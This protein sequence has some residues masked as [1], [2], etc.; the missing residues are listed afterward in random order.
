MLSA[1]RRRT[2]NFFY[3]ANK[4][5]EKA[6]SMTRKKFIDLSRSCILMSAID[7]C[8]SLEMGG[9]KRYGS[10]IWNGNKFAIISR[11]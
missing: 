8:E 7:N 2:E 11:R 6:F 9:E 5:L 4:A 3:D 1:E 10:S